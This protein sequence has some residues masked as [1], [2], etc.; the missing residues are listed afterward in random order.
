MALTYG[1]LSATTQKYYVPKLVDNIFNSNVLLQRWRKKDQYKAESGGTSIMQ[2]VMYAQTTAAGWYTG[3]DT[4]TTTAND[5][6]T[7]AEFTRA[8]AYAN[9]T[10]SHTDELQNA[11]DAQMVDFVRAKVQAAEMTLADTIG[12]GLFNLGTDSKAIIG[13]R[14]AIDSAGTYGGIDRSSYSWWSAQEDSSSTTLTM[15]LLQA[16]FGDC[17]VGNDKPSV[18]ITT[19]DLYDAYMNTLTPLQRFQDEDTAKGGFTNIMFNGIPVVV[20][21][22]CPASHWF[23]INEKYFTLFYH[24]KDN[25]RFE[26]FIKPVDQ[27]M[28]TAKIFWAGQLVCSNPR[29][30][31]KLGALT[32]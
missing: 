27:A 20:D 4:L 14:L 10:I 32:A 2:P 29:M 19:Q 24:P 16:E 8:H 21:S 12:T 31:A 18:A 17:T 25:F 22:H 5:Q 6:I 13:L 9:I 28:A 15:P 26:P 11:G 1:E 30:Q 23:F 3:S 7:S